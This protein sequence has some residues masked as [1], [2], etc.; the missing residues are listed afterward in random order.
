MDSHGN[1]PPICRRCG[2][3]SLFADG[4]EGLCYEC[5]LELEQEKIRAEKEERKEKIKEITYFDWD[6]K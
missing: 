6:F 2:R 1:H 5:T 3:I 4:I